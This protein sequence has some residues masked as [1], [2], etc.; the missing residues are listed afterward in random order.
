MTREKLSQAYL[1]KSTAIPAIFCEKIDL[2]WKKNIF[3]TSPTK[4]Q[5]L[6]NLEIYQRT[7]CKDETYLTRVVQA[8][9][10]FSLDSPSASG[11]ILPKIWKEPQILNIN[12]RIFA[13]VSFCRFFA[14][15][16]FYFINITGT[17][18]SCSTLRATLPNTNSFMPV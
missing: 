10:L 11:K 15:R 18:E 5:V 17:F 16:D 13:H 7:V 12:T 3:Y 2:T 4:K 6:I 8:V 1:C 14:V 9:L